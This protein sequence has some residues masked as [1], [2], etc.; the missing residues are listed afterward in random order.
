MSE[1]HINLSNRAK[2]LVEQNP[3]EAYELYVK[4]FAEFAEECNGWDAFN[5]IKSARKSQEPDFDLLFEKVDK[6]KNDE[7]VTG[8]FS[9]FVFDKYIKNK[10]HTEVIQNENCIQKML[11]ICSQ[12]DLKINDTYPCPFTIAVFALVDAHANNQFNGRKIKALLSKLDKSKLS[13]ITKIIHTEAR[14]D[15]ELASDKEKYYASLTKAQLKLEEYQE[16]LYHC[17]EALEVLKRYHYNNDLWFKMRIALSHEGLGDFGQGEKLFK[18]LLNSKAGADKWFLYRDLAELYYE[19]KE[20]QR[21]YQYSIDSALLGNEP[22]FLINLY[23]LQARLLFKLGQVDNGK[24]YAQLIASILKEQEWKTKAEHSKILNYYKV[25]VASAQAVKTVHNQAKAIWLAEKHKGQ[26]RMQG[27]I[28][29]IHKNGKSGFIRSNK[30]EIYFFGKRDL[31]KNVRR[32][33]DLFKSAVSFYEGEPG[34]KNKSAN[35]VE[36]IPIE[37]RPPKELVGTKHDGVITNIVD[38][39]LFVGKLK[40]GRHGLVHA[41]KL[42]PNF[43]TQFQKGDTIKV[44]IVR[45][46]K[47]NEL[48]LI[49]VN[50]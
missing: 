31:T 19:K 37:K 21:A 10:N 38:F 14:G 20:Y 12:K 45:L 3:Q 50:E 42:A 23:L 32:L 40:D 47:K 2:G 1:S 30:G 25:D 35:S 34:V 49:I 9:W 26:T 36:V 39:G 46:T 24:V 43:A 8:L 33:E 48:D 29:V 41:S 5:L 11:K 18:E 16:C 4:L 15:I 17:D 27:V 22:H 6:Y 13:E 28:D 7:K 44:E